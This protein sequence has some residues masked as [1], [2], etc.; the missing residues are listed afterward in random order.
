MKESFTVKEANKKQV[1]KLI[2][3]KNFVDKED[4]KTKEI[5]TEKQH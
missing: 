4:Q 1:E 5:M 3:H 2:S